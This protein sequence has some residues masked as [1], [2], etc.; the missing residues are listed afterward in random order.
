MHR[1]PL[2]LLA[3]AAALLCQA[4]TAAAQRPD[5]SLVDFSLEQLSE[6][7]VTSVSRQETRLADAPASIYLISGAEIRRSGAATLPEALRLAPNLQVARSDTRS[8]AVTARGF[9]STIENKLLVMIDG[10]SVYSPLFSGVFWD[11][12]DVVMEDIERIEVISGPGATIWGANAVNGVINII[13]RAAKDTQGGLLSTNLGEH[14]R[15][16]T[17]R[18]GGA[19]AGG[20][21]RV[22][23]MADLYGDTDSE[24]GVRQ[25]TGWHRSQAGFRAD[26][27]NTP[28][29]GFMLSGDTYQGMLS[30]VRGADIRIAG[31]NLVGRLTRKFADGSDLRLQAYLDHTERDQPNTG[32]QRLDTLDLEAQQG[33]RLGDHQLEWGGGYRYTRDRVQNGPLL[34]FTPA[35]RILRWANIFA[36]DELALRPGL[37]LTAGLKLEHNIY[38]GTES[39]PSLRLA[40][41][42]DSS[43]LVWGAASRTVRAPSRIDRDL[44]VINAAA[45]TTPGAPLYTIE[46]GPDFVSETARVLELGYR[47]QPATAVSYSATLFYS[48]YDKLRTLESPPGRG[49]VFGNLAEGTAYGIEAWARWQ[50]ARNWR[51]S[52]G[53]VWQ[54]VATHRKPGS[55]D[56]VGSG[57][58][59]ND[60]RRYWSLRSAH[61]LGDSVQ[62]DF[63]LRYMGSLPQPAVPAY[64]ELDARLAWQLRRNVELALAGQNLLHRSHAEFGSPG[65][66]QVFERAL[67]LQLVVRL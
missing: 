9:S 66:R 45:A 39:L 67:S 58:N 61:D 54:D 21:Y 8:Y 1:P 30:Q 50:P 62:A 63:G 17:A 12:Q 49:A 27:D 32:A 28:E 13:T 19:L 47:S 56:I 4:G 7:V 24:A 6:I 44:Y 64:Y 26:W 42:P 16:G 18:Y 23:A 11:M 5:P 36:Q 10:R 22:Y 59:A 29:Q 55:L 25:N 34:R 65:T 35:E 37:R 38:T 57:L 40:W 2:P 15:N 51:L 52:A 43:Q 33:L 53:A 14:A 3:L 41:N 46:G 20:Y 60:P 31:G 48:E